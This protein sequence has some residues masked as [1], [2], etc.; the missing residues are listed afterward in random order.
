MSNGMLNYLFCYNCLPGV[1]VRDHAV[2]EEAESGRR[3]G[4]PATRRDDFRSFVLLPTNT[5]F[6]KSQ[7]LLVSKLRV[8]KESKT[9]DIFGMNLKN[10]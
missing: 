6:F 10:N 2:V 7:L 4:L 3:A 5:K 8:L 9:T 1:F